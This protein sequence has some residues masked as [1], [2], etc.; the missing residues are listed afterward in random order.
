MT[1]NLFDPLHEALWQAL[2]PPTVPPEFRSRLM[3]ALQREGLRDL[4]VRRAAL[5]LEHKLELRR[6]RTG[7][8][9]LRRDTLALVVASAFTAGA[10]ASLALPWLHDTL[11]VGAAISMP[12][13]A[14]VI[15]MATG[16]SVWWE[17]FRPSP[18]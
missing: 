13:I 3:A 6:L 10:L 5:E 4:A 7:Y 12:L 16:A 11:G 15:G 17:R 14:I 18:R 9:R 1:E 8:V 2:V